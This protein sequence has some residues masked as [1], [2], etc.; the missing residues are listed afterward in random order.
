MPRPIWDVT[1]PGNF[2][3]PPPNRQFEADV[4]PERPSLLCLAGRVPHYVEE[5]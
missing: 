4:A 2:S 1:R 3:W 5:L